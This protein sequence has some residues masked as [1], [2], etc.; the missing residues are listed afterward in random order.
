LTPR[1]LPSFFLTTVTLGANEQFLQTIHLSSTSPSTFSI[2]SNSTET[3]KQSSSS[4]SSSSVSQSS[5]N[6]KLLRQSSFSQATHHEQYHSLMNAMLTLGYNE[7]MILTIWKTIG[8]ILEL[9][10][11]QFVDMDSSEGL[12]SQIHSQ[13]L[14]QITIVAELLEINSNDLMTLFT[15]RVVTTVG[16]KFMKSLTAD[17]SVKTKNAVIKALYSNLFHTLVSTLNSSLL[18]SSAT[19]TQ[20]QHPPQGEVR[21]IGILD[22]FGFESFQRNELEQ[23]LINYANESLQNT[24][25]EQIFQNELKLYQEEN[26][27]VNLSLEE[28]PSNSF[29]VQLIYTRSTT[30]TA[31]SAAVAATITGQQN[32]TSIFSILQSVAQSPKGSDEMFCENLHKILPTHPSPIVRRYFPAVHPKDRKTLFTINHF[33]GPVTYHVGERGVNTW[34]NKNHD[35]IPEEMNAV[36]SA[37]SSSFICSLM[38]GGRNGSHT[39]QIHTTSKQRKQ[40][41][42]D[43]FSQSMTDLCQTLKQ[44]NCSFIRCMKP[45]KSSQPLHVDLTYIIPQIRALGLVQVCEVMKVGLTKRISFDQLKVL[46]HEVTSEIIRCIPQET[47]EGIA[48]I[49]MWA[50]EIPDDCYYIGR[51]RV[52]FKAHASHHYDRLLDTKHSLTPEI[53]MK[54]SQAIQVR[55]DSKGIISSL[56]KKATELMEFFQTNQEQAMMMIERIT[57]HDTVIT[58]L[59]K[60]NRI[61]LTV[62]PKIVKKLSTTERL[63]QEM[64]EHICDVKTHSDYPVINESLQLVESQLNNC[65][66]LWS[67]IDIKSTTLN[68]F[69]TQQPIDVLRNRRAGVSNELSAIEAL[70][71]DVQYLIHKTIEEANR[72]QLS[73]LEKR[74]TDCEYNLDLVQQRLEINLEEI[75][76]IRESLQTIEGELESMSTIARE[77]SS[78]QQQATLV[79]ENI[80][81]MCTDIRKRASMIRMKLARDE[82]ERAHLERELQEKEEQLRQEETQFLQT[83]L[84]RK[85]EEEEVEVSFDFNDDG[86]ELPPGWEWRHERQLYYNLLTKEYQVDVPTL[87]AMSHQ[88]TPGLDQL[89]DQANKDEVTEYDFDGIRVYTFYDPDPAD[90][91]DGQEQTSSVVVETIFDSEKKPTEEEEKEREKP[92]KVKG[93][94][95]KT[96]KVVKEVSYVYDGIRVYTTKEVDEDVDEVATATSTASSVTESETKERIK[97]MSVASELNEKIGRVFKQGYLQKQGKYFGSWKKLYFV[98]NGNSVAHYPSKQSY[99]CGALPTKII[100]LTGLSVLSYLKY[101]LCFTIHTGGRTY[102]TMMTEDI[103]EFQQWMDKLNIVIG[104]LFDKRIQGCLSDPLPSMKEGTPELF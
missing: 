41:L 21:S 85:G 54:I 17:E 31:T 55:I 35:T 81:K 1:P 82:E 8:A 73:K 79:A 71:P 84:S 14:T 38:N 53:Q 99:Q 89:I 46:N 75:Q 23:L 36:F 77:I 12:V 44:S 91:Q 2:L 11:I 56:E 50:L 87:P 104:T 90:Q 15:K 86:L 37:S 93:G 29:C 49:L 92:M 16:E 13:S 97:Q 30:N 40:S 28:C 22:I 66:D 62:T 27:K 95:S 69:L 83:P 18:L 4:S 10:N 61:I 43:L 39:T 47:G 42:A 68:S 98:I 24:F 78:H 25:N 59:H 80:T 48:A 101:N 103:N 20:Q 58:G 65:D 34:L 88:D 26:I 19:T 94:V 57:H 7:M 67:S 9:G 6:G 52:F 3:S 102:W 60:E 33:A 100:Q 45:N 74:A 70:F 76:S 32:T 64:K 96:K 63:V 72:C 5:R 51:S